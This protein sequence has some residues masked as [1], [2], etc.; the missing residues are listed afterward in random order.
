MLFVIT[1]SFLVFWHNIVA[2]LSSCSLVVLLPCSFSPAA[3]SRYRRTVTCGGVG[4]ASR[5]VWW[6]ACCEPWSQSE[7]AQKTPNARQP[8]L[9]FVRLA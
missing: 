9:A 3:L 7:R 2:R 6:T 8:A 1:I 5:A 4:R